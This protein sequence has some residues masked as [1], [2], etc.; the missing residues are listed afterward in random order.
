M[1]VV[2]IELWPRGSEKFAKEI[3]R[4]YIAN[5]GTGTRQRS[6]YDGVLCRRGTERIPEPLDPLGP[7]P[8]RKGRV[9]DYP[10]ESLVVW[11]LILRMLKSMFIGEE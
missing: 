4:M 6:S 11:K 10:R 1:I 3:G 8:T 7:E 5:D 2:K 9:E